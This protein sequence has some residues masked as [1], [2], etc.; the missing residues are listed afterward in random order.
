[1]LST[2]AVVDIYGAHPSVA[3][4]IDWSGRALSCNGNIIVAP[5]NHCPPLMCAL[6]TVLLLLLLDARASQVPSIPKGAMAK[7]IPIN[8]AHIITHIVVALLA[9]ERIPLIGNGRDQ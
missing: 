9:T 4:I 1:M 5:I 8:L 2:T 3:L 7:P 6:L